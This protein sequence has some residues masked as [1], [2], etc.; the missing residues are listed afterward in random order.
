[1]DLVQFDFAYMFYYSERPGT[2]AEKKYKDDISLDVKKRRLNEII[3]KQRQHSF[4]KNQMDVGNVYRVLI[5]GFSKRSEDDLQGRTTSNKVVVFPRENFQ[6]GQYVD[7]RV[8]E[9][10]GG[11]LVGEAVKK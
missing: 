1:M 4:L 9:C 3:V 2:L 6:K 11:T 8:T 5:E 10:T 7:V